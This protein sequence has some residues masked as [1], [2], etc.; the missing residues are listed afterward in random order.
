MAGWLG[1]A[2]QLAIIAALAIVVPDT[3][4]YIGQLRIWPSSPAAS[5]VWQ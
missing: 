4:V 2:S 1:S 5:L 3:D